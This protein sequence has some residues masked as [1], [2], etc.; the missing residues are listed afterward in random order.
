MDL[1]SLENRILYFFVFTRYFI[2]LSI[3]MGC[4]QSQGGRVRKQRIL[5]GVSSAE[6]TDESKTKTIDKVL[7]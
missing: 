2:K 6:E 5:S 7:L 4:E 3:G 1:F